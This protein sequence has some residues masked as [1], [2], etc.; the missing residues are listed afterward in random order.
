MCVSLGAYSFLSVCSGCTP[1]V[2]V[3]VGGCVECA[4]STRS[5][6]AIAALQYT[7]ENMLPLCGPL[8]PTRPLTRTR[9]PIMLSLVQHNG[10][11][12]KMFYIHMYVFERGKYKT[13]MF[14]PSLGCAVF[15][16]CSL[17]RTES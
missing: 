6:H 15:V 7:H 8:N 2:V 12:R 1:I 13:K 4:T 11:K 9:R 17:S 5:H 10:Q 16:V 14:K 3:V